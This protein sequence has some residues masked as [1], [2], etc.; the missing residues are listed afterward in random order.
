MI[1]AKTYTG[2]CFCGEVQVTVNGEPDVM[3]FIA[4]ASHV[5]AGR[6]GLLTPSLYGNPKL[7]RS[8]GEQTTSALTTKRRLV[9]ANGARRVE[10]TSSPSI[11]AEDSQTYTLNGQV[12][13]F[14][15]LIR[16]W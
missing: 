10:A 2:S 8:R 9:I 11:L 13:G 7:C 12:F 16:S 1:N 14:S 3:G 4:I 15:R 6:Q 5:G